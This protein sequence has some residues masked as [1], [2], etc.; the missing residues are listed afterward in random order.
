MQDAG[1]IE[2]MTVEENR[3]AEGY[4]NH[5]ATFRP[6]AWKISNVISETQNK[7]KT[8]NTLRHSGIWWAADEA[9]LNVVQKLD[10]TGC[11]IVHTEKQHLDK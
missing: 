9:E 11:T 10:L 2:P 5:W 8:N 6:K 7:Q 4:A 1:G 3:G